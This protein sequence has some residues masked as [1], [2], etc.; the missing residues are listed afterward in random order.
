MEP[1]SILLMDLT[2][3]TDSVIVVDAL[4]ILEFV[5]FTSSVL[6]MILGVSKKART[7]SKFVMLTLVPCNLPNVRLVRLQSTKDLKVLP[8]KL[9]SHV[10]SRFLMVRAAFFRRS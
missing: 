8:S 10:C 3:S 5:P 4:L 2:G 7:T 6:I 9:V 1:F